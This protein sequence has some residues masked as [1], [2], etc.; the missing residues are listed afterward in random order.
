MEPETTPAPWT[1]AH[2]RLRFLQAEG[3]WTETV[4]AV[5]DVTQQRP[6]LLHHSPTG[7]QLLV[8]QEAQFA[9]QH[10]L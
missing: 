3:R 9:L 7:K 10:K 6:D 4:P 5:P 8:L 1:R 2:Q